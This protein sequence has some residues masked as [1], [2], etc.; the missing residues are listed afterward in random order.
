T[1]AERVKGERLRANAVEAL[2]RR[3]RRERTGFSE[4]MPVAC[5]QVS[6]VEFKAD[7]HHRVRAN[8]LRAMLAFGDS[9]AAAGELVGML[10]DERPGHRL[11]AVWLASRA[12][13]I[14][15]RTSVGRRWT[16]LASHV[17]RMA[18]GERDERVRRRAAVCAARVCGCAD[19]S[20][21]TRSS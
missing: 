12:L 17:V 15:G 16:E 6:L 8:A 20:P 4:S 14:D 1:V 13:T 3:M 2:A 18:R 9:H 21:S 10:R 7:G 11:A 19:W 5:E